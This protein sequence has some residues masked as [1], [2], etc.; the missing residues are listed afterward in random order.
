MTYE[1]MISD[2]IKL[3]EHS[4]M[5]EVFKPTIN[6]ILEYFAYE[7]A[8]KTVWIPVT[9]KL[10]VEDGEYLVAYPMAYAE[11]ETETEVDILNYG[12][13][14]I[15]SEKVCGRCWYDSD[16][17]YGDI[18]YDDVVAWMPM[19]KPYKGGEE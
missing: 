16:S 6:A 5:P 18:V 9:E 2:L 13:P 19:P 3:R 11:T 4:M 17:E 12:K 8:P 14:I 1:G 10:P 15:P 7:D